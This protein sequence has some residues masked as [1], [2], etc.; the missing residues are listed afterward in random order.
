MDVSIN[1]EYSGDKSYAL[2]CN[3]YAAQAA[4]K[5][6]FIFKIC[7]YGIIKM[8]VKRSDLNFL[9]CFGNALTNLFHTHTHT[10]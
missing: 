8:L 10:Q 7:T 1:E 5:C 9:E 3:K 6:C 2:H 4:I